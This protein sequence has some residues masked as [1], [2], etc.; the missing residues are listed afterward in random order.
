[1]AATEMRHHG[2]VTAVHDSFISVR[3][4]DGET[5]LCGSCALSSVCGGASSAETVVD[6]AVSDNHVPAV[7]SEVIV[8]ATDRARTR[9]AL[10]LFAL[11]IF[12]MILVAVIC[13][14]FG[15]SECLTALLSLGAAALC[16]VQLYMARRKIKPQ[17]TLL[18]TI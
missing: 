1:M 14:V 10:L 2:I 15:V 11:P 4:N 3:L 7:G 6:A 13:S 16:F 18:K 9:A 8:A 12:D 5:R 17:W